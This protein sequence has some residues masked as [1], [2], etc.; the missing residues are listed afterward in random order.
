M[1]ALGHG[2]HQGLPLP[3]LLASAVA[4]GTSD[5]TTFG[6]GVVTPDGV[7]EVRA[8]VTVRLWQRG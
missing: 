7:S 4:A 1:A 8:R 2:L 6:G 5:V 3:E